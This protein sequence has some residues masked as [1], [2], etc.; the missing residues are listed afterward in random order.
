MSVGQKN[1]RLSLPF[2]MINTPLQPFIE[3]LSRQASSSFY[4]RWWQARCPNC[5]RIP[6]VAH[7][8]DRRRYLTCNYCGAEYRSDHFLCVNCG[9][10]DPDTLNYMRIEGTSEYQIDFCTKCK[11]YLK[12]IID[13]ASPE[14]IPGFLADILTLNLD[15][16]AQQADLV[17]HG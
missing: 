11:N 15:V 3:E 12:V 5:G 13:G 8:R 17:K 14:P 2:F 9:N 6:R 7:I 4:D 1:T 10:K 16:Q